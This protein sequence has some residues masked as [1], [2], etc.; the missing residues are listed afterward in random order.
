[1]TLRKRVKEWFMGSLPEH[2]VAAAQKPLSIGV[3]IKRCSDNTG[4]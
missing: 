4:P 3:R 1:M 2:T